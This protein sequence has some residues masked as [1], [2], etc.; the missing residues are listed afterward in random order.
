MYSSAPV[1]AGTLSALRSSRTLAAGTSLRVVAAPVV[2]AFILAGSYTTAA[3]LFALA[4][5]TDWFDGRLARRW[6]VT[7]RFG[8]FLD[9]T[10]DKVLVSTALI[11]LVAVHRASPWVALIIIGREFAILGL[12]LAVVGEGLQFQTSIVGKWK[13]TVQFAAITLAIVRPD[14]QIAG[15]YLDQWLLGFAAAITIWSG[16]DYVARFGAA[17]R[18]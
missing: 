13:A 14:V 17:L 16:V 8:A 15:A 11:G 3:I 12:R 6:G 1:D 9:T 4:A 10:A 7:S 18:T 2:M 5:L